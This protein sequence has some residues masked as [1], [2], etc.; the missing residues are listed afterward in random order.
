MLLLQ[1]FILWLMVSTFVIGGAIAFHRLFPQESPWFGFFI[2]PLAFV[3]LINFIEH[4]AALPSLL[5]LLP[6]F[7]GSIVWMLASP[8]FSK[9]SLG[10]PSLIFLV[11]FAFTFGIR[12]L[13]PDITYTSD[14]LADLNKINNF[15]QGDVLPPMDTWLPPFRYEWY[16]SLQHYAASIVKR[17]V[18]IK[19]GVAYNISHALLSAFTCVA[20]A[21][22]AWRISGGKI[23]IT[24]AAP[25]LIESAA[26]GSSAYIQLF[27]HDPSLWLANNLSGAFEDPQHNNPDN[28]IW[29]LLAADHHERLELQVPGFWTWRDEYH[30][31]SSGHFL[32][33]LSVFVISEL[34]YLRRSLW[35]WVMAALIP[36]FAII[37]STWA[38][39]ITLL[40]CGGTVIAALFCN[41]RP[42]Q[43]GIT[44]ALLLGGLI[45][46]WPSFYDVTSS[47]EAPSIIETK[48]EWATPLLE[49]LIQWWPILL[50]WTGSLIILIY[51]FLKFRRLPFDTCWIMFIV[52]IMLIGIEWITVEG[53]YNTVEKMWGYTYGAGLVA[54]F[55]FIA[56]RTGLAN[57]FITIILLLSAIISLSGWLRNAWNWTP[58]GP[59]HD[60][61]FH[62]EGNH[63]ILA[64][65]QKKKMYQVLT[66]IRHATFLT[67]KCIA[68][69]YYESPALAVFTENRSYA[70]WTYFESVANYVDVAEYREKLNN[71]FYSG[72]MSNRLQF[73]QSNNITGIFIW[74]D[75]NISN[76]FLDSLT[77]ELDPAYEYIDCRGNGDKNAG[78]F[79]L[80]TAPLSK[81][82]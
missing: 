5:V 33:L 61:E 38:F 18:D 77:K 42:A 62:L 17:L 12:C 78:V 16:Y 39:P 64:D 37:S 24:C 59:W 82:Y 21:A 72:S 3:I 53:R 28:P 50:L 1:A 74:P 25:F 68:F 2:P 46:L 8:R 47:P 20:G 65:D 14:G 70:T 81:P 9:E 35:P 13:Q 29:K 51:D 10:L 66:Q 73:L 76:D 48:H 32:T 80:R 79:L 11:S 31:N 34:A 26:T 44:L 36:I 75:D 45:L 19:L 71:D 55:P 30:A 23:W 43:T 22:A 49:F 57:R 4:F 41:R 69:N 7:L 54:L 6:L 67:G 63:Y 15:C 40:L 60:A 56:R 52:P 27:M 58:L